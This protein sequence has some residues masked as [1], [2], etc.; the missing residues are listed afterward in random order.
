MP[1]SF[2]TLAMVSLQAAV[3]AQADDTDRPL[4]PAMSLKAMQPRPG[5]TVEL[6][7]AEPLVQDPIAFAFGPDGKLWVVEMGDYPLG[8]DGKGKRGGRIKFL[9]KASRE[10]KRPEEDGPYTK[11][12]V[13]LD[14]LGYPTGVLPWGK[15]VLVTC[16]PDIFYAEDT[17]GDGKADKKVVLYTGFVEGN[18]QHRVNGLTWGLDNWVYGANGD[19]GGTIK[20]LKTGQTVNISGRD[21][22]I[23]PDLGLIDAQTG[24]SQ[25]GRCRDDW[26]NWFGC[27]NSN[28]MFHF[29]LEDHYMRRNPHL[30][31]PPARVDVSVTP[32]ASRVYPI[33]RTLPRFNNPASANH[34]TS[35]CSV[36][37]YRDDLF[38]PE[39]ANNSFV[40]EPVHNLIHREI[41]TPK[42]VTFTSR[43]AADEQTS[44]FLASKDSWFRPTMVQTGP[45]G[46]LWVADMYRHV[47]EHPEW[48]PK[49]WQKK[50][51]L[52]AGHDKGRIY[53][54]YPTGKKPRAI[55]RLDKLDTAGLV[56]SLDSPNGWQRDMAQM[57]LVAKKDRA[58]AA[59]L[60]A[61]FQTCNRAETRLQALCTL[62]GLDEINE[63][64]LLRVSKDPHPGVRRHAVR[65][66]ETLLPASL[67]VQAALL[68]L[69]AD[70][71]V[72]VRMQLA[73][74]LGN[75]MILTAKTYSKRPAEALSRLAL[76]DA[77]D[78]YVLA[79]I[80]SSVDRKNL[81]DM[82]KEII[83]RDKPPP[84]VLMEKLLALASALDNRDGLAMLL[85]AA[86]A[87]PVGGY[88]ATQFASLGVLL[89]ALDRK[90]ASLES[91]VVLGG[92]RIKPAIEDLTAL[93][94]AAR[95]QVAAIQPGKLPS[96]DQLSAIPLL[97]RGFDRLIREDVRALERLLSPRMASESQLAAVSTLGKLRGPVVPILLKQWK[98]HSPTLRIQVLDILLSRPD[99]TR[100]ALYALEDRKIL[101]M[102]FDAVRRQRL[103]D[104]KDGEI[105]KLAREVFRESLNPDRR[106]VVASYLKQIK[107]NGDPARG[108]KVFTKSCAA[109]HQLGG[110]GQ[111]VG[112]D[113][114]SVP[115]KST[116][117]MLTAILDPNQAVESRYIGYVAVTRNGLSLNG[118]LAAETG[119]SITLV[120]ADGK[121]HVILRTDLD[122]LS[123]TG[124]SAMPEGLEKEISPAEMTD[125][126]AFIRK[127][128]PA[129]RK[130][131]E[132]GNSK[133]ARHQPLAVSRAGTRQVRETASGGHGRRRFSIVG[134]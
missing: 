3:L 111:Q 93:Y 24:Q 27:N 104:H 8:V 50:L 108:A 133:R 37:I 99:W 91:V 51:D 38:G 46:A 70:D 85:S 48:I 57:M 79:A 131:S 20:S 52:R 121:K 88:T 12:T 61:L 56:A 126:L 6:M 10:R 47:I 35:A 62:N 82:L 66:C 55:P 54:I 109:C 22:R 26:G 92:K 106:K 7:A 32:G 73:S 100:K 53:R 80:M 98:S 68:K 21:F 112:P 43:R 129:K 125:L 17:D 77:G 83:T 103:V 96:A 119:T 90:N 110:V 78:S 41:M 113:L 13:F 84:V 25:F 75:L 9:E 42:G 49:E 28:P 2:V 114:A 63:G 116:L 67:D 39:F 30:P 69:V 15:G 124:K 18:Q 87:P 31:A 59:T 74:S 29:V 130:Q 123:S 14:N 72:Q 1:A 58:A 120:A 134:D 86:A 16:A 5:C 127:S 19:S 11:A 117:A 107:D 94:T 40:C 33:S 122:E 101:P 76:R 44:E 89:D 4:S 95:K 118:L 71:D 60:R 65:L 45:D 81:G 128:V 36:P 64:L 34:F 105:R 97:G 102:D 23:K 115:D 132:T